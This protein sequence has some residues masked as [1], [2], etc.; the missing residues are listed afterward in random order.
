MGISMAMENKFTYL[1]ICMMAFGKIIWEM[2][3]AKKHT[4]MVG[5]ILEISK[6]TW[7]KAKADS[8]QKYLENMKEIGMRGRQMGKVL[9][10]MW[11]GTSMKVLLE[12]VNSMDMVLWSIN[13]GT[14]TKVCGRM[15]WRKRWEYFGVLLELL[16]QANG[17]KISKMDMGLVL[18]IMVTSM[19]EGRRRTKSMELEYVKEMMAWSLHISI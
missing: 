4:Q 13:V 12:H 2:D 3:L 16:T 8:F 5:L 17:K 10:N 11:T 14:N 19:K 9:R 6:M 18:M 15:V 1:E 7:G